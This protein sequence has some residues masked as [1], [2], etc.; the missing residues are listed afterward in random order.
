MEGFPSCRPATGASVSGNHVNSAQGVEPA[1]DEAF[2]ED[3]S[4]TRLLFPWRR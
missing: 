3:F 2:S 4:A 1:E